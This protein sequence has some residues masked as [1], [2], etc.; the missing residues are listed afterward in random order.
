MSMALRKPPVIASSLVSWCVFTL[1]SLF[2]SSTQNP[3]R[4]TSCTK[5]TKSSPSTSL[6]VCS[7]TP[8][9]A[10]APAPPPT[11]Y[12]ITSSITAF[13]THGPTFCTGWIVSPPACSWPQN[14]SLRVPHWLDCSSPDSS[15]SSILPSSKAAPRKTSSPSKLPFPAT[16]HGPPNGTRP[17]PVSL[18]LNPP[19]PVSTSCPAVP[20]S[21]FSK[22]GPSLAAP[23]KFASTSPPPASPFAAT[24]PTA[25]PPRPAYSSIPSP[26]GSPTAHIRFSYWKR[27]REKNL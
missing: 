5:T 9:P 3:S 10:S 14:L 17:P 11:P 24:P 12:G 1:P 13:P 7:F 21:H 23:T 15:K 26:C 25:P 20:D 27:V 18:T 4:S 6:P 2:P 22:P 16:P 19:R 8:P